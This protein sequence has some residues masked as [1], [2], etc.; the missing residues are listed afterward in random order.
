M[1]TQALLSNLGKARDELQGHSKFPFFYIDTATADGAG[2]F[3]TLVADRAHRVQLLHHVAVTDSSAVLYVVADRVQ[4]IFM[5]LISFT[6]EHVDVYVS[7]MTAL[8][9]L[10]G[11]FR[12]EPSVEAEHLGND[13]L[14]PVPDLSVM[15]NFGYAVDGAT[16]VTHAR[17]REEMIETIYRTG[18]PHPTVQKLVPAAVGDYNLGKA[19][20]DN[21]VSALEDAHLPKLTRQPPGVICVVRTVILALLNAFRL[22]QLVNFAQGCTSRQAVVKRVAQYAS[23]QQLRQAMRRQLSFRKFMRRILN[24]R[25]ISHLTSRGTSGGHGRCDSL[26]DPSCVTG[27]AAH[28]SASPARSAAPGLSAAEAT[29]LRSIVAKFQPW[30]RQQHVGP[31]GVVSSS[32]DSASRTYR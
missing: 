26:M 29:Q 1:R 5:A 31:T 17:L 13:K 23:F 28:P 7:G 30:R 24:Q 22:A 12:K 19:V 15:P 6:Y 8:Y 16:V 25:S 2:H 27:G 18:R 10:I 21:E 14:Y 20:V 9:D 3:Q 32:S 4:P 11:P